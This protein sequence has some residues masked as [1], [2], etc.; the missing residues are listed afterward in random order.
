MLLLVMMRKWIK[1]KK[2]TTSRI[3]YTMT[4]EN[5]CFDKKLLPWTNM[6]K[7]WT[8]KTNII[9]LPGSLKS[10]ITK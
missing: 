5:V 10:W 2:K 1:G 3:P 6:N 4:K 9:F 8:S 7:R